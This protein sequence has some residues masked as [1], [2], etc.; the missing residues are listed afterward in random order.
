MGTCAAIKELD[1][2]VGDT[3]SNAVLRTYQQPMHPIG[4]SS[5]SPLLRCDSTMLLSNKV[6]EDGSYEHF[7]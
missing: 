3:F 6:G 1:E 5:L 7:V 2:G 4:K